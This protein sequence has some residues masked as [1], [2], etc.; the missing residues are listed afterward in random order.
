ME[1]TIM[2]SMGL[3][4]AASIE[5]EELFDPKDSRAKKLLSMLQEYSQNNN[6]LA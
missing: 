5:S 4:Y 1:K 6:P 3:V 2:Y